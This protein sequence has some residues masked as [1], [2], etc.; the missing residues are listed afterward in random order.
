MQIGRVCGKVISTSK[1]AN[2]HGFSLLIVQ[3]LSLD[4]FEDSGTPYVSID[5]VGAG[6]GEVVMV[7]NGSSARQTAKT[8]TKPTDSTIVAIVDSVYIKGQTIFQK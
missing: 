1:A 6:E 7:V 3:P 8:D 2:L 4:T 5:T